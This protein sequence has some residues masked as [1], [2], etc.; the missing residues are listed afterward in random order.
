MGNQS[1]C[2]KQL[3]H[4]KYFAATLSENVFIK[5]TK[6]AEENVEAQKLEIF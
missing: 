6:I 2:W 5:A 3:F 1:G 4:A